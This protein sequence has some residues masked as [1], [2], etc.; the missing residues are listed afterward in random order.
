MRSKRV[1]PGNSRLT[2]RWPGTR[3]RRPPWLCA[4]PSTSAVTAPS[5]DSARRAGEL[6]LAAGDRLDA[7]QLAERLLPRLAR[8]DETG[9]LALLLLRYR[10]RLEAGLPDHDAPLDRALALP[11]PPSR[12][13]VE[14]LV[15]DSL[16]RVLDEPLAAA[17]QAERALAEAEHLGD[18]ASIANAAGA[19]GLA[20]AIAR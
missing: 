7:D 15:V 5:P 3:S 18:L 2:R 13:H 11:A 6:S 10:A 16:R 19:A 12:E 4:A 14:V 17:A 1:G 9:Q 8:T 20:A